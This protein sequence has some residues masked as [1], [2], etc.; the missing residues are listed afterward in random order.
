MHREVL[1]FAKDQVS[2]SL[3]L[4]SPELSDATVY[5]PQ[6]RARLVTTAPTGSG[7]VIFVMIR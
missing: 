5:E 2:S 3:L 6:I 4:A 1:R 7:Y